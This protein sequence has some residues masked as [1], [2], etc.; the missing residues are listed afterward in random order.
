LN[1]LSFR[2]AIFFFPFRN[3]LFL[4]PSFKRASSF[5]RFLISSSF[6]RLAMTAR[7]LSNSETPATWTPVSCRC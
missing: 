1:C 7:P 5:F 4:F 2:N 6:F 3:L